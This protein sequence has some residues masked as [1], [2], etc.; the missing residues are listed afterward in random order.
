MWFI[1]LV[2]SISINKN[3]G[4]TS[5][6]HGYCPNHPCCEGEETCKGAEKGS[7]NQYAWHKDLPHIRT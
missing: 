6:L 7:L 5:L 3:K 1:I 4:A 2:N